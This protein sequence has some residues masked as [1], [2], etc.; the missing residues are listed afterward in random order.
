MAVTDEQF[1]ALTAEVALLENTINKLVTVAEVANLGNILEGGIRK[2]KKEQADFQLQVNKVTKL[3]NS[4]A[5]RY[6]N[7]VKNEAEL[8]MVVNSVITPDELD[9][10]TGTSGTPSGT[11]KFVTND[12]PR[13]TDAR[14]PFA[15][16]ASH[17]IGGTDVLLHENLQGI[18]TKSHATIDSDII[19]LSSSYSNM[20]PA[21]DA[22]VTELQEVEAR[23]DAR[24]K[25]EIDST[26]SV[27]SKQVYLGA[28]A[29]LA[30]GSDSAWR[31]TRLTDN[32]LENVLIEYAG[33]G[34]YNQ[35][36]DD[37]ASLTYA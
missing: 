30:L 3:L 20:Q 6:G 11:N 22:I 9:A 35:V 2:I 1:D 33:S 24:Y 25:F 26:T 12:D 36:W 17:E 14:E 18:G 27:L 31:I 32:G 5:A 16:A 21:V 19:S 10:L 37:R 8:A 23:I 34:L 13:M 29:N 4:L 15:H 28:A 7:L